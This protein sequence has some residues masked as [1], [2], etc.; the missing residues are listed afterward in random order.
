M[1]TDYNIDYLLDLKGEPCPFPAMSTIDAYD[2]MA[3]EEVIEVL[4]D[5]PQSINSIPVDAK[6]RGHDVLLV[7]QDGPTFR[8]VIR[9]HK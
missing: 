9:V 4:S 5:C 7:Q 3:D 2:D 1:K 6:K 8:Y